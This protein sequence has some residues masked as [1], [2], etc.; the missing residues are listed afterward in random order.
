MVFFLG[1]MF[2]QFMTPYISKELGAG[3][4]PYNTFIKLFGLVG[5]AIFAA[6][7]VFG[8]F[9]YL[10]AP[11]L[12]GSK[13]VLIIPYLPLYAISMALFSLTSMIINY[14][15][16]RSRYIFPVIGF[17]LGALQLIGMLYVHNSISS[18]VNIV[19]TTS[20]ISLASVLV[21]SHITDFL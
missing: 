12:W 1:G 9:G 13:A 18:L 20:V 19:F 3:K 15:Q 5:L 6:V 14:Q 17:V 21:L 7:L 8:V 4:H 11:V 2:S 10:T 16:I